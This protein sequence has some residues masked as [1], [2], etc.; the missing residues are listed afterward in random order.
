MPTDFTD[1]VV[2]HLVFR[3]GEELPFCDKMRELMAGREEILVA[4][5]HFAEFTR[6]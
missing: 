6:Q 4:P 2:L 5:A 1:R 3:S